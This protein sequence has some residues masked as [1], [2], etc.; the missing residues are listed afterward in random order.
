NGRIAR[1]ARKFLETGRFGMALECA[2]EMMD[3]G[4]D[5]AALQAIRAQAMMFFE[6]TDDARAIFMRYQGNKI[7]DKR[8]EAT[9]LEDFSMHRKAGRSRALMD[10]IESEF[11]A[12][13]TL[14]GSLGT[15]SSGVR[16]DAE[17]GALAQSDDIKSGDLLAEHGMFDEALA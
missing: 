14:E 7:G 15:N 11:E 1:M 13:T 8:W 3:R 4:P 17:L 9:I 5:Q 6:R 16:N 10:E 12:S 2:E